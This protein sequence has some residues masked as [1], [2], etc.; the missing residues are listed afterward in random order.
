MRLALL[1]AGVFL[2]ACSRAAP[3]APPVG[4]VYAQCELEGDKAYGSAPVEQ[5][6]A[7]VDDFAAT[8][9]KAKGY[10]FV[11]DI[12]NCPAAAQTLGVVG[13]YIKNP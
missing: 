6:R 8:C 13:C 5:H 4:Q 10:T 1:C 7:L 3:A 11:A 2:A 9:M 12:R